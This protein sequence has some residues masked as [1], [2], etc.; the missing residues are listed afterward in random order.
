M[1]MQQVTS[2]AR[3]AT[4]LLWYAS[5]FAR[6]TRKRRAQVG[7]TVEDATELAGMK[8]CDWAAMESGWLPES[9]DTIRAVAETLE[10]AWP[11]LELLAA[12]ARSAQ[13]ELHR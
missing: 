9:P 2:S 1:I 7:L 13:Q 11:D 8:L 6:Y 10:T 12:F 5:A 4:D 3:R